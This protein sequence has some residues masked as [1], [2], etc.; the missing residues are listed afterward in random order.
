MAAFWDEK[1]YWGVYKMINDKSD[2]LRGR[3]NNSKQIYVDKRVF[4]SDFIQYKEDV[5]VRLQNMCN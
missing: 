5:Y 1:L 3:K 2:V 4:N